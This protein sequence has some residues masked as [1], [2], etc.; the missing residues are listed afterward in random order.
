[1]ITRN[2]WELDKFL[3]VPDGDKEHLYIIDEFTFFKI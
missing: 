1:M 3:Q 2:S